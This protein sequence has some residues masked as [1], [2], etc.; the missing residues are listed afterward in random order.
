[1]SESARV[2]PLVTLLLWLFALGSGVGVVFAKHE[3]RKAFT[4]LQAL[5][6]ERDLLDIEWDRL[7][8]EQSTWATH[9]RIEQIS[10]E[11]LK[12]RVPDPGQIVIVSQ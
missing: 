10:R 11:R 7:L 8:L 1:M 6:S 5:N 12:M 4:A 2:R 3:A 9:A